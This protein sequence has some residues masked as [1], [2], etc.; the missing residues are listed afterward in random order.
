MRILTIS[1]IHIHNYRFHKEYEEVF[2]E[3]YKK[4]KNLNPILL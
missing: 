3:L 1:D 2:E 4:L